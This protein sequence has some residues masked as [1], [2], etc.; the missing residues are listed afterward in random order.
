MTFPQNV[1]QIPLYYN[2]YQTGRPLL[3]AEDH[4]TSRYI[5]CSNEPLFPFGYGLSYTEFTYSDIMVNEEGTQVSIMV[6]NSGAIG[7]DTVVQLYIRDVSASVV[8]P[9]K[10]LKAFRRVR[11]ASGERQ[12]VC[13]EITDDMLSFYNEC[14]EWGYEPGAFDIMIGPD[15]AHVDSVRI[16][17]K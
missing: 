5:D 7:G 13:F 3:E 17:R 6:E 2:H 12:H 4:F 1:G 10:E 15:S 11:L 9:V 14:E 8:R 16:F